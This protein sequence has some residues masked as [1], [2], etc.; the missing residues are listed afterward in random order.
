MS[1]EAIF[2]PFF[3][4]SSQILEDENIY[5]SLQPHF[6]PETMQV[7]SLTLIIIFQSERVGKVTMKRNYS[8][9]IGVVKNHSQFS[10]MLTAA[11]YNMVSTQ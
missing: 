1:Y 8:K 7:Q 4:F 9:Q 10:L 3:F 2:F 5:I 6:L 11:K